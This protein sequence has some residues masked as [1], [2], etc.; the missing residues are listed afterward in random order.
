[1]VSQA[2]VAELL[3]VTERCI[4]GWRVRG[5]GPRYVR[6]GR[7]VRYRESDVSAWLDARTRASTSDPGPAPGRAA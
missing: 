2:E 4:E 6:V 3:G 5:G 7:L 1:M